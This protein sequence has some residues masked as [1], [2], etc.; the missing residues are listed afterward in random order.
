MHHE[1]KLLRGGAHY[2]KGHLAITSL[3]YAEAHREMELSWS[4]ALEGRH[5]TIEEAEALDTRQLNQLTNRTLWSVFEQHPEIT[6]ALHIN[7]HEFGTQY[8]EFLVGG[9]IADSDQNYY[10][11]AITMHLNGSYVG[12]SNKEVSG[13]NVPPAGEA[14]AAMVD[15][16]LVEDRNTQRFTGEGFD[17][18]QFGSRETTIEEHVY[19][20]NLLRF[21]ALS[22]GA[23]KSYAGNR[24]K[25]IYRR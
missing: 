12:I 16:R 25:V 5:M 15:I 18:D 17:A 6:D 22:D 24:S 20:I 10:E 13:G 8:I 4:G 3:Q 23:T 14:L 7:P 11:H 2:K 19:V 1:A 9:D 21:L